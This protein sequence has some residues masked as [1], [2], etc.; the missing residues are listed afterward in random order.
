MH[1]HIA[2]ATINKKIAGLIGVDYSIA[3]RLVDF[4]NAQLYVDKEDPQAIKIG[5]KSS[6]I[7]LGLQ[8][9]QLAHLKDMVVDSK[10]DHHYLACSILAAAGYCRATGADAVFHS[11]VNKP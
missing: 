9:A 1:K 3:K 7:L 6:L 8:Y 5:H 11:L 10:H 4:F 2:P